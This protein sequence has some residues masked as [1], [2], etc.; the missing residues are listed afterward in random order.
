MHEITPR[1]L[2]WLHEMWMSTSE[3]VKHLE[4]A[5]VRQD[6]V[7]SSFSND[8]F[9]WSFNKGALAFGPQCDA[10][11]FDS[12]SIN[13][14]V[15]FVSNYILKHSTF[16]L[17]Q[18]ILRINPRLVTQVYY[19]SG[20]FQCQERPHGIWIT[21]AGEAPTTKSQPHFRCL[22]SLGHWPKIVAFDSPGSS[23]WESCL[24]LATQI[25][26]NPAPAS[27]SSVNC[28]SILWGW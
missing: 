13:T 16:F 10:Q 17:P 24:T 15:V 9:D 19:Y 20:P 22:Y 21:L 1:R 25:F 14:A 3:F 6:K 12:E 23:T 5:E 27:S 7:L 18:K 2:G 11:N 28:L 8:G 26:P 4:A